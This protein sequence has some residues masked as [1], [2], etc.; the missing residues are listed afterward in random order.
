M[1]IYQWGNHLGESDASRSL[2]PDSRVFAFYVAGRLGDQASFWT[3]AFTMAATTSPP[4]SRKSGAVWRFDWWNWM[5]CVK[6]DRLTSF[7]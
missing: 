4:S 2:A 3:E 5:P 7:E 1:A 6:T